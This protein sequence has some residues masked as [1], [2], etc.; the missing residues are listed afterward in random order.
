MCSQVQSKPFVPRDLPRDARLLFTTRG[1]RLFAYGMISV[2]LAL[3]LTAIGLEEANIGLLLSLTLAGD[4]VMSLALTNVADRVGRKRTLLVGAAL[5]VFAGVVFSLTRNFVALTI[6][7]IVG[8]ISPSGNEVGPFL[9][10]EQAALAQTIPDNSRTRVFAWYSLSGS[11]MTALGALCGG[12]LAGEVGR[13]R[14]SPVEGYRVVLICYA[15]LG[16]ALV[17]LFARLS[18]AA[19]PA[20]AD[21]ARGPAGHTSLLGLGASQNAIL[22]LSSL[23]MIDA[24][25]GGLVVQS[26]VA[27]WFHI[28]FGIAPG[29]LGAIFFGANLFAAV[30]ALLAASLAARFGLVNTIVWT[31]VPSNILLMLIPLM[32][33]L[34]LAAAVLLARFSIS[35]MDVPTRQSYTMALVEPAERSA[36][37]GITN[38]AR[39]G[40]SAL[41]PLVTGRLFGA[42]LMGIP[43][44][45]AGALKIVYDLALYVSFQKSKPPEEQSTE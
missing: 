41:G 45:V 23:F 19:E 5:V 26:L 31:H 27:Y 42:A 13:L 35:Q 44:I 30:S 6:A 37:A 28:K 24:F 22:K 14:N 38:V 16:I 17:V 15:L 43:F 1:L 25:A 12:A 20:K 8:T 2:V 4:V 40:A 11:F 33:N 32:P 10:V 29:L 3:Y 36:A 9:A 34:P 18:A 21:V 39:T 7:A